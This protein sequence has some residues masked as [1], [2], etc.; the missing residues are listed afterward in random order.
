LSKEKA[1]SCFI[2]AAAYVGS[3]SMF[4]AYNLTLSGV[5]LNPAI[6]LGANIVMGAQGLKYIW[7]YA[8]VPFGGSILAILFHELVYKKT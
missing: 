8:A 1:I 7:L 6:G 2:I 4:A 3:R 5:V